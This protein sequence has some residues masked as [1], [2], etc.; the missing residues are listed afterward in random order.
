MD[1]IEVWTK[2]LAWCSL[3]N[4]VL[5]LVSSVG[6]LVLR[7]PISGIHAKMFGVE[8]RDIRA[9]YFRYLANY[10]ILVLVFN[11]VPYL[12]LRLMF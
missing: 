5:L 3:F 8:R 2:L 10:K 7:G 9:E 4:I 12:V 1:T 6:V 11:V